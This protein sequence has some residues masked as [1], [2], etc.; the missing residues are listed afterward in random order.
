MILVHS[1]WFRSRMTH[2][3]HL[4]RTT[5]LIHT[6]IMP[7]GFE[8]SQKEKQLK[9]NVISFVGSENRGSVIPLH[10]VNERLKEMLGISMSSVEKM[11]REFREE[12]ERLDEERRKVEQ[13]EE[14][15]RKRQEELVLR[16]RHRSSSRA[17][18]RFSPIS[19]LVEQKVPTARGPSKAGQS[20][21]SAV[22][23]SEQQEEY[24]R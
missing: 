7:S 8:Y 9:F 2:G 10:N 6:E 14:I 16:L 11:K 1:N 19:R 22:V 18:R 23:L 24:I 17:E 15:R 21:R 3:N 4:D 12:K 5:R 20:R 13:E